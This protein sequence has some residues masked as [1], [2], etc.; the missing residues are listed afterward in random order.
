MGADN[1]TWA[2]ANTGCRKSLSPEICPLF[3][4]VRHLLF[5]CCAS[6]SVCDALQPR[7]ILS[8]CWPAVLLNIPYRGVNH[9]ILP[10]TS[11]LHLSLLKHLTFSP[12][13][14]V[15]MHPTIGMGHRGDGSLSVA[16]SPLHGLHSC[17]IY[18]RV[19]LE[20]SE[21][22]LGE[23]IWYSLHLL[24]A[25]CPVIGG[26]KVSLTWFVPDKSLLAVTYLHT[27]F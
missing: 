19:W 25:Y 23:D 1:A 7:Q 21:A 14:P 26:N 11:P 17:G 24:M 18:R 22:L 6:C 8:A 12:A 2:L 9:L 10:K 27:I 3:H 15:A 16:F 20:T 13:V 5:H 4:P